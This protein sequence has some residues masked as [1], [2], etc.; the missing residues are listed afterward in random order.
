[1][2]AAGPLITTGELS[3]PLQPAKRPMASARLRPGD[4]GNVIDT[5]SI[6]I[7]SACTSHDVQRTLRITSK[8]IPV[9]IG[10]LLVKAMMDVQS[11]LSMLC[12]INSPAGL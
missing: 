11:M 10:S 7:R 12:V 8:A 5:S 4:L 9:V 1:V 2:A 3:L 6:T